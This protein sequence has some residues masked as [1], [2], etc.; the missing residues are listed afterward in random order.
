MSRNPET[1][2]ADAKRAARRLARTQSETYQSCLDIVA[3]AA[4]RR[5]W[6]AFLQDPVDVRFLDRATTGGIAGPVDDTAFHPGGGDGIVLGADDDR[7]LVRSSRQSSVICIGAV[8][9]GKTRGVVLPT[10][11]AS[12]QSS[13]LIHDIDGVILSHVISTG[14]RNHTRMIVL[15]P[16]GPPR[17]MAG[18]VE[19]IGFNPL[20]P[21]CRLPGDTPWE[22]AVRVARCLIPRSDGYFEEMGRRL[23][24]A[25]MCH[26]MEV[27]TEIP[28]LPGREGPRIASLPAVIDWM[29]ALPRQGDLSKGFRQAFEAADAAGASGEILREFSAMT[30]MSP[31]ERSGIMGTADKGLL[32]AKNREMRTFLDPEQSEQGATLLLSFE[33]IAMP[34]T[35]FIMAQ[36]AIAPA[37]ATLT[38]LIIEMVGQRRAR[39]GPSHRSLQILLDEAGIL[40][41][42]TMV[43]DALRD[44]A[45][46]GVSIL[47]VDHDPPVARFG[48][49]QYGAMAWMDEETNAIPDHFIILGRP[50][51]SLVG[52]I[53]ARVG[54]PVSPAS[55]AGDPGQ[56]MVCD[57][58]GIRILLSP[59]ERRTE[60]A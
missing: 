6:S 11:V 9:T 15:D 18:T 30:L 28:P 47:V 57:D 43:R 26:L 32:I 33:D 40:P 52:R 24:A 45:P 55:L 7:R 2:V 35:A 29:I 22:H 38:G 17:V 53:S 41:P 20:H 46:A 5:N 49:G 56:H 31:N 37:Q 39:Q 34:V 14:C 23:L 12:P 50:S 4:G 3:Q 19:R 16:L 10:V 59:A 48:L 25:I 8:A 58:E 27:P 54:K 44:G 36:R 1:L 13:Q 21:A 51:A 60:S 42:T